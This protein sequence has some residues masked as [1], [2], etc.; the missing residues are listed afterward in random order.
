MESDT[1]TWKLGETANLP[2][3]SKPFKKRGST[4]YRHFYTS[5]YVCIRE[6]D[7]GHRGILLKVLG[8]VPPR[9]IMM[10]GGEPFCKD[11]EDELLF[12]TS[13][14][15][16]RFPTLAE[17][18]DVLEILRNDKSLLQ[19]LENASMHLDTDSTFWVRESSRNL[20]LQR[21]P[22]Y[23]DASLGRLCPASADAPHLRLTM[24]YFYQG[25]LIV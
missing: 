2:W 16:F 15:S 4:T 5:H 11:D 24:V 3:T 1:N 8:K 13:Y 9:K 12:G 18:T 7:K 20:L 14:A 17:L 21:K 25:E 23:Y 22:N 6:E 19:V 10:I